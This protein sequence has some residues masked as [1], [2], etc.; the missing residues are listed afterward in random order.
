MRVTFSSM[1]FILVMN[2]TLQLVDE[3]IETNGKVLQC[4]KSKLRAKQLIQL[5]HN[6]DELRMTLISVFEKHY[7]QHMY[8]RMHAHAL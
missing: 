2:N 7:L 1:I 4:S 6:Y 5:P 3:D 8:M